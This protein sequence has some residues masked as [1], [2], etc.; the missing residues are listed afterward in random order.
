MRPLARALSLL[1]L[2]GAALH[3]S[4]RPSEAVGGHNL[5]NPAAQDEGENC[6]R[7]HEAVREETAK[8][9]GHLPASEG[10]CASCHSPHAARF[11][12]LL[13]RRERALCYTCHAAVIDGFQQGSVHTP[14]REGQCGSCHQVHGSDNEHL[15]PRTG[16]DLCLDC[17]KEHAAKQ[18]LQTTHLPFV[19]G[20]CTDCHAAHNSPNPNQLAAPA[21]ALCR[22]CHQ[23]ASAELVQAHHGIGIDGTRCT[24]CHD[25]HAAADSELFLPVA[26]QP[27]RDGDC[28]LCHLTDS[29]TPALPRATGARLCGTCHSDVPRGTDTS[30]HQPVGQGNCEACHV[31]HASRH[32]GLLQGEQR[33]TCLACH[34]DIAK[35]AS[36]S[37]SVHPVKAEDKS[38]LACHD[39]HSSS[40]EKLLAGGG[41]RRCLACHE[42]M[43]HGHPL[44]E[45]RIDPRTGR[46]ITCVTC[47]DPHGTD[48][49][50]QLR[51]DQSRGLC[52][53]CHELDAKKHGGG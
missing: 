35:R 18:Q 4:A 29:E 15:L 46:G 50:M 3:L 17:H 26:H 30:V 43:R 9:V 11:E 24:S 41:I 48:F 2:A 40:E 20:E 21:E 12:H 13:N 8:P 47:H 52:L 51:G 14:V 42:T 5:V 37:R 23:P 33:G 7:C 22:L 53:E 31:P 36:E 38:C 28:D 39:P 1:A 44:G 32:A 34:E 49:P 6:L 45:D 25:A 16:N 19:D 10:M 27:F